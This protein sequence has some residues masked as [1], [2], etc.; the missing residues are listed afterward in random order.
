M[1]RQYLHVGDRTLAY[2]DS[3]PGDAT[4]KA[5]V[6]VH[7][8]P[9]AASMWEAQLK[10]V[11]SGWR[12][13]APDLRGFG[14]S[15]IE[16]DSESPSM[17]DY[18]AD[19]VD[20]VR[21][22]GI[23]SA[24]VGGCSMGGYA[25]FALLRKTPE[26][27][28]ALVLV[29]TRAGADTL[30][31]RGNRRNMLALLDREGPSGVAR[32]MVPKLLGKTTVEERPDVESSVRRLIKQQSVEAIRGAI[33]RIMD[34]PDSF[35]TLKAVNLPALVV[36]GEEDTL[37]PVEESRKLSAALSNAELVVVPRAGHLC[38]L[39]QP[40]AFNRSLNTFLARL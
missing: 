13:L 14:G 39:E 3:A 18:A 7:A 22:L 12:F 17:D 1:H 28:R 38:S 37:T 36:V 4:A 21:E 29:D 27:A 2:F 11:P 34:R 30:E 8:F 25:L 16:R 33:V 9:L 26:V 19:V 10:A 5:A 20:L 32:D 24:V 6:F 31:G 15:T 23:S 40:D 35:Q